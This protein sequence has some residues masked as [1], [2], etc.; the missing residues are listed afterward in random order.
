MMRSDVM[1]PAGWRGA[2]LSRYV[3]LVVEVVRGFGETS[4]R[5]GNDG[6][7]RGSMSSSNQTILRLIKEKIVCTTYLCY[8]GRGAGHQKEVRISEYGSY[9]S[10]ESRPYLIR[11]YFRRS[12]RTS[13]NHLRAR[14]RLKA[15]AR[16]RFDSCKRLKSNF[17]ILTP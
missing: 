6:D 15:E 7:V 5:N 10:V 13:R 8:V 16:L 17:S 9:W 3:W 1:A 11:V 4:G 2:S 12:I 14:N